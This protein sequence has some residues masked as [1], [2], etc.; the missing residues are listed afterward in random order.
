M[1]QGIEGEKARFRDLPVG[2][3]RL[4]DP[5]GADHED[6][7]VIAPGHA[8]VEEDA[9]QP[10]L[11]EDLDPGLFEELAPGSLDGALADLDAAARKMPPG[12]IG[13]ADEEDLRFCVH[14]RRADP[15]GEPA[16]ETPIEVQERAK[17]R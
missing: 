12:R 3:L 1:G 13:V 7:H 5:E 8:P 9:V 14:D 11:A 6:D 2:L 15:E 16:R 10:R 4:D 17:R